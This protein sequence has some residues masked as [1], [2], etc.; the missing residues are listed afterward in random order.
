MINFLYYVVHS[1]REI[2]KCSDFDVEWN[3]A[4][5]ADWRLKDD[6]GKWDGKEID[7]RVPSYQTAILDHLMT[8]VQC[9]HTHTRTS[10]RHTAVQRH[11]HLMT[12]VQCRHATHTTKT[13]CSVSTTHAT[14]L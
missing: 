6:A 5:N 14:Y 2:G 8:Y 1:V 10:Q 9:R 13:H 3:K 4:E 12:Y 7:C 11:T